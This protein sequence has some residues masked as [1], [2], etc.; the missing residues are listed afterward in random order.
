[1]PASPASTREILDAC[2]ILFGTDVSVSD[3]FLSYLQPVGIKAAYRK[4]ALETHPDRLKAIG[5]HRGDPGAL[6]RQVRDAYETLLAFQQAGRAPQPRTRCSRTPR[7]EDC[8]RRRRTGSART[9]SRRCADHYY[10]GTLPRRPLLLGQFLYYSGRISWRTLIEAIA[11][12]RVQR[13]KIG[14][15]AVGWGMLSAAEVLRVLSERTLH[16]R[17]GECARRIGAI[18]AFEHLALIGRQRRLQRPLG[19]YFVERGLLSRRLIADMV[20]RQR[21]HNRQAQ[22]GHR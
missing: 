5:R 21:R 9:A 4:R 14:H 22:A 20:S 7:P 15:I 8:P 2:R 1:M 6:F 3:A 19:D 13:P 18:T 17:F 10:S 12:Q 16:E 11:W